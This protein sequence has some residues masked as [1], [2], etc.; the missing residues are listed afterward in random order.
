MTT[1]FS[2]VSRSAILATAA[3]LL[4]PSLAFAQSPTSL[5]KGSA[6]TVYYRS[7]DNR[8]FV[9]PNASVFSSWYTAST[10]IQTANDVDLSSLPLGGNVTYRPGALLVKVTTDPKVY[11][12]SRY[13]VLRWVTTEQLAETL[14]GADWNKKIV[15]VPDTFFINYTIGK[16][17]ASSADYFSQ[18]E[19]DSAPV[20]QANIKSTQPAL[21]ISDTIN[22][23]EVLVTYFAP[24]GSTST[25]ALVDGVFITDP[26]LAICK[27]DCNI[28]L[29]VNV[30]ASVTAFTT[31]SS[32][33][34]QSNTISISAK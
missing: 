28:T 27:S 18:D 17:I 30:P 13:G 12:V 31:S 5:I 3:V 4:F 14:Y 1:D 19:L 7:A 29:H 10:T 33:T 32:T 15:D 16:P 8:R 25:A 26:A 22:P 2:R 23:Q 24:Y 21:A 34:L 20:P 9:F 6:S 11:A